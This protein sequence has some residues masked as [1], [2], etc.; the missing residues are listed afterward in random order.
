M[1]SGED[2]QRREHAGGAP[3]NGWEGVTD[4]T[5][6]DSADQ[7]VSTTE[8]P[9]EVLDGFS[10]EEPAQY[11]IEKFGDALKKIALWIANDGK[12]QERGLA[13]RAMVFA[14]MVAP[15]TI[16][17]TTQADLADRMNLSRSQV[18]EYVKQFVERFDFVC[19][20]TYT[21]RQTVDRNGKSET[22]SAGPSPK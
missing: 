3:T 16:G 7:W 5:F 15:Q 21:K 8:F 20:A 10:H 22:G 14:F 18:N 6:R 12:F 9:Y 1:H 4:R 11:P 2:Y 13:D 17:C 19:P